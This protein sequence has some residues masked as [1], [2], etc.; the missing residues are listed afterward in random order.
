MK[1]LYSSM[2]DHPFSEPNDWEHSSIKVMGGLILRFLPKAVQ[3][4]KRYLER[5]QN[6][7]FGTPF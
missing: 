6:L 5:R 4:L 3:Q 7:I 2:N 1:E